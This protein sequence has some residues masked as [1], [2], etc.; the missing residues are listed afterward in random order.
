VT[1]STRIAAPASEQ[2]RARL[3]E[4][5]VALCE[6]ESP[7]RRERPVAD[8]LIAEVEALGLEVHEDDSG[9][10]TGSDAGNLIVNVPGSGTSRTILLDAHMDTVPLEA[11]VEVVR[12][13]GYFTNRHPAI[14]GADN[15]VAVACLLQV[16]RRLVRAPIP[17]D[18][19]LLFT[20][21]EER[22]V[23]GASALDT[24]L[25][26]AEF[27][28]VFDRAA[29]IGEIVV[30]APDYYRIAAEFIGSAAH[31]GT[32]PEKG[33]SAIEAAANALSELRLGRVSSQMTANAGRIEGGTAANVV[34]DRC[35]VQLEARSL[36]PECGR[37]L[38]AEIV[39]T[40]HRA[41]QGSGCDVEVDPERKFAAY[42]L[43]ESS[44]PVVLASQAL[45]ALGHEPRLVDARGGSDA[46][47]LVAAG[48]PSANVANGSIRDH[49]PDEAVSVKALE[50]ALDV[51]F[52]IVARAAATPAVGGPER[53]DESVVAREVA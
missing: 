19:E 33:R 38:V 30:A 46:N 5:F 49:E 10:E 2:E 32:R 1:G 51:V 11:P 40:M 36:D 15:K 48:I 39:E 44:P 20:T 34:A 43:D 14:L 16:A 4:D 37:N 13:D 28:F 21:C 23:A 26:N 50:T 8:Y 12:E 7:S 31:A 9:V 42:R 53:S 25:I 52:E 3:E 6:L 27:A 22:A 41:A 29:P 24:T 47:A 45:E 35:A 17:I 18:V